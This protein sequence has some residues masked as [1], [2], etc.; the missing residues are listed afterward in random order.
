MV[1]TT[2]GYETSEDADYSAAGDGAGSTSETAIGGAT[3]SLAS[4]SPAPAS[5]GPR[6]T[7]LFLVRLCNKGQEAVVP[8]N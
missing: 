8:S 5:A 6:A 3:A 1:S 4:A 7:L 2:I